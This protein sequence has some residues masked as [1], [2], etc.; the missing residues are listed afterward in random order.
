[1]SINKR[2][3][4]NNK[5]TKKKEKDECKKRKTGGHCLKTFTYE[6]GKEKGVRKKEKDKEKGL[7]DKEHIREE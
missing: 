5:V 1:M 7:N 3:E 6:C 4:K 2:N